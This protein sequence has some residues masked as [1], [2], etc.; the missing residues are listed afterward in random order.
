MKSFL[1]VLRLVVEINRMVPAARLF[2]FTHFRMDIVVP[3]W[4]KDGLPNVEEP[5]DVFGFPP[6]RNP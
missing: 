1:H 6:D 4:P 5:D 2:P 3:F